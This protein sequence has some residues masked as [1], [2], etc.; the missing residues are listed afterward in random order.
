MTN[1]K[2]MTRGSPL[3]LILTFA[4]PLMI[5][6][7][8]QQFYTVVD[9]MGV[10]KALGVDALA[11]LGATDWLYWL[12]LGMIQGIT[13][14]FGILMAREFGAKQFQGL[15]KAV[16]G[17]VVLSCFCAGLFLILGQ[18]TAKPMLVWMG[19]P[20]EILPW[21]LQ[22]LR[23]LLWGIPIVMAYNLLA[24]VL[25]SLGDGKSP[26]YAMIIAAFLNI[27]LD[28]V[29]VLVFHWG[30]AGAAGAT[31]IAQ[32]VSGLYCLG[33]IRKIDFMTLDQHDFALTG[34]LSRRLLGLGS[35][36]A[37]QN[38]I[39]ALGG[40][41]IQTVVNGYG[42]AFIGGFTATN[43]LYGILEIAATSYGYAMITY[44]GQNLGAGNHRRIR[45]GI[46]VASVVALITSA[47]IAAVMLVFGRTIIASFLSGTPEEV[48]QALEV[49]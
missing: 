22:Y 12:V 24:T 6:N 48:S 16:G 13:Q 3:S 1:V 42:V 23:L 44:V 14:G 11:A 25:R 31:L 8:F 39:I 33:K 36:I 4:F 10:G 28:L 40:M 7:V 5:G 45:T 34:A 9:T 38:A 15:R 30:V 21:S 20:A 26:L 46:C 27:G 47:V 43:K 32:A 35:P 18:L 19:T 41:I 2:D 49:G 37:A 29:F 17:S